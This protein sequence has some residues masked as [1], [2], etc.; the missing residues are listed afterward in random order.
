MGPLKT[1]SPSGPG[2]EHGD[3]RNNATDPQKRTSITMLVLGDGAYTF[4][5]VLN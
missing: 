2:R 5:I 3:G 4:S 1:T